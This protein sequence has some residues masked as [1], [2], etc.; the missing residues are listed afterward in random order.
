MA[1]LKRQWCFR[2]F[3]YLFLKLF[4]LHQDLK[5]HLPPLTPKL[6]VE[7][8][9][10]EMSFLM[11]ITKLWILHVQEAKQAGEGHCV[12]ILLVQLQLIQQ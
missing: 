5:Q 11:Q 3:I 4:L 10:S 1:I 12:Q 8:R 7:L 2:I 6:Y 9:N